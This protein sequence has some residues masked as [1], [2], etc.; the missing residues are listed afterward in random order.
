[1][2]P[3]PLACAT[4]LTLT[5]LMPTADA[6]A[7]PAPS[8]VRQHLGLRVQQPP[9]TRTQTARGLITSHI[10]G[11]LRVTDTRTWV[12]PEVPAHVP[13]GFDD[14]ELF[15][16]HSFGG[17]HFA[18]YRNMFAHDGQPGC[19]EK[20]AWD[21][22]RYVGRF[23]RADGSLRLEID[24]NAAMLRTD[25]L[26]V[27]DFAFAEGTLYY[28]E[29]C[30]TY[31][32]DAGGKC[33]RVLALDVSGDPPELRWKSGWLM[34]NAPILV[35]G[36]YLVTGYGFTAER[37][38]LVVLDRET[39]RKVLTRVVPK[40]PEE[41]RIDGEILEVY[42]YDAGTPLRFQM[43]GFLPGAPDAKGRT[44]RGRPA[45]TLLR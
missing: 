40:A 33:S 17:E 6:F 21:N 19:A 26:R 37:D 25:H 45:L 42:V 15:Q 23:Y 20:N 4:L 12:G 3:M 13:V 8:P 32:K 22:C 29:P 31:S 44:R 1:M 27:G 18:F 28:N 39:G 10:E 2:T 35:H 30:Q 24:F 14:L 9:A 16:L 41:L 36:D 43:S 7:E 5:A 34:S 38:R 11:S